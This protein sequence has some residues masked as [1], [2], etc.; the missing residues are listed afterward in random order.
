VP[1][2]VFAPSHPF[3]EK[4]ESTTRV[5]GL[6]LVRY[7]L[8]LASSTSSSTSRLRLETNVGGAAYV[9]E[10]ITRRS[11]SEVN[12]PWQSEVG[13]RNMKLE[14][15][16]IG[17]T[18]RSPEALEGVS[19]VAL[20][21]R[22]LDYCLIQLHATYIKTFIDRSPVHGFYSLRAC[23]RARTCRI[24]CLLFVKVR[25]LGPKDN[26]QPRIP[27]SHEEFRLPS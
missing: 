22:S 21:S 25:I 1:Q 13:E 12:S 2:N 16:D 5:L 10:E 20:T 17:P 14:T 4:G 3:Y 18:S 26:D 27:G 15:R 7:S 24:L 19:S 9:V 8:K 11:A 6:P 23:P